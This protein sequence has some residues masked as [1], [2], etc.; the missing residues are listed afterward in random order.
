MPDNASKDFDIKKLKQMVMERWQAGGENTLVKVMPKG[1]PADDTRM[2]GYC[3]SIKYIAGRTPDEMERILGFAP[4]TKLR[5]G[6]EIYRVDP[7]P[8]AD[9]FEFRAYSYL[10]DGKPQIDGKVVN[11]AYPP[12]EGA[13]QWELSGYPQSGLKWLAAAQPG[14]RFAC[15]YDSL[16][17]ALSIFIAAGQGKAST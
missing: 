8:S 16:P 15:R 9:Q 2:I 11:P 14:Q 12:G 13:P 17:T 6:A 3:T 4:G 10:P 5:D 7:L 1:M